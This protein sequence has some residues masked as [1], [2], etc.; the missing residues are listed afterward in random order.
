MS[1][2]YLGLMSG[3][4]MDGVDA[5]LCE[6]ENAR[7]RRVVATHACRYGA[8]LRASL[9]ALQRDKPAL[10]LAA[11]G[12]LDNAVAAHFARAAAGAL[13]KAGLAPESVRAIGSHGQTVFHDPDGVRTS[14][15]LGN[16]AQ[17]A[18][19]TGIATVADFRRADVAA[20]G[21]GAP[22]APAFHHAMF[23]SAGEARAVV[24]LGGI[25]N[26]TLLPDAD[27]ARVRGFDT[28]PGN[29]LLDEW[30]LARRGRAFDAGGRWAARG[31]VEPKLLAALLAD[32]WFRRK[33]PKSTGRDHFNLAWARRRF[34]TIAW[35][36]PEAVQRTFAELTARSIAD[37]IRRH[38]PATRRVLVCG[39][40]AGNALLM[41]RLGELL[42]PA[43]VEPT[44]AHGLDPQQVEGAA[45]AWLALR[46]MRGLPGNLPAVTGAKRAVV[47]GGIY[48][49]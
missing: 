18:A 45:F 33:P 36:P 10:T 30:I 41:R 4:S 32:P 46:T 34:R 19:L 8:A 22:L 49:A 23:A 14:T 43:V 38:A 20:G 40:G 1:E 9:L 37:A 15:Q 25:A 21:Q 13:R 39:G 3:T 17:I 7:L 5:A 12:R 31:A 29:G 35:L 24:N 47:L 44:S 2:L 27:A 6:Y 48:R 26:V 28:G 42:A 11:L 16:P